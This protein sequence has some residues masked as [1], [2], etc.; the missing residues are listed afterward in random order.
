MESKI[1]YEFEKGIYSPV[2]NVNGLEWVIFDAELKVRCEFDSVGVFTLFP[3]FIIF[4]S[5]SILFRIMVYEY[6]IC[7]L[8]WLGIIGFKQ[9]FQHPGDKK[10][11]FIFC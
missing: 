4:Y 8:K 1:L 2:V 5:P 9:D 10:T 11:F 3:I 6:W 7:Y